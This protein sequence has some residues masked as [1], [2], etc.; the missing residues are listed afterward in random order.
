MKLT[1]F[2]VQG[3]RDRHDGIRANAPDAPCDPATE[4]LGE[5]ALAAKPAFDGG[6]PRLE[7]SNAMFEAI[8]AFAGRKAAF[9]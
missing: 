7:R 5:G 4:D 3:Y 8:I 1:F 6:G 2:H 9:R